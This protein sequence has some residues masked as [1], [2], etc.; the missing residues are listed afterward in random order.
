MENEH[1]PPVLQSFF[2]TLTNLYETVIYY[3]RTWLYDLVVVNYYSEHIQKIFLKSIPDH[4]EILDIGIGTGLSM[5]A[6][7]VIIQKKDLHIDRIET[8]A[9]YLTACQRYI[10]SYFLEKYMTIRKMNIYNYITEKKYDYILFSDSSYAVIPQVH[11]MIDHCKRYLKPG[12]GQIII[13]TTLEDEI[14]CLKLLLKPRLFYFTSIDF[15]KVTTKAEFI[16]KIE[17]E[18]QLAIEELKCISTKNFWV[19][20]DIKSYMAKLSSPEKMI[21]DCC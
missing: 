17:H 12:T 19:Y 7:K 18:N 20:G 3:I 10:T 11:L 6:N 15:G 1:F 9:D 5:V 8:D 21:V 16:A 2:T 4:A 14:T 13:L